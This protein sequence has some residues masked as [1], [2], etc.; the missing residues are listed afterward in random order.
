M[1]PPFNFARSPR[2]RGRILGQRRARGPTG[3][4]SWKWWPVA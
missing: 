3:Q 1:Q 2:P 4:S